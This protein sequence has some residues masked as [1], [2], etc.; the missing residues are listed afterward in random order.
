MYEFIFIRFKARYNLLY[1]GYLMF[2]AQIIY[3]QIII[4][5]QFANRLDAFGFALENLAALS[6]ISVGGGTQT[7]NSVI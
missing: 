3:A 5:L 7:G 1:M 4:S 6:E 2:D